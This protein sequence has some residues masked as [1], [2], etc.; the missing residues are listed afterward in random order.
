M[1]LAFFVPLSAHLFIWRKDFVGRKSCQSRVLYWVVG[2]LMSRKVA[3]RRKHVAMGVL[4]GEPMGNGQEE[5][6][7]RVAATA[8]WM[9]TITIA[10]AAA[11]PLGWC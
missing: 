10:A 8:V 4:P 1:V 9:T 2:L 5:L 3:E 7:S 6:I 11:S